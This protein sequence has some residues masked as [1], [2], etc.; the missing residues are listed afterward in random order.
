MDHGDRPSSEG[1]AGRTPYSLWAAIDRTESCA[2]SDVLTQPAA[3]AAAA[4]EAKENFAI[5][6]FPIRA[7]LEFAVFPRHFPQLSLVSR[8]TSAATLVDVSGFSSSSYFVSVGL[9][10]C[11]LPVYSLRPLCYMTLIYPHP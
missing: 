8:M 2:D 5:V 7:P 4:A 11:F 1:T 9:A 6:H 3:A 10:F